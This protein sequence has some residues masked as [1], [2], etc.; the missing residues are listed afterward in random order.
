MNEG[1]Y[2]RAALGFGIFF[3]I[4]G[5]FFLLEQVGLVSIRG[6]IL[7]PLMLIALGAALLIV[8]WRRTPGG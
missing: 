7:W 5:A 4:T 2:S 1:G 3:V 8:G 6:S